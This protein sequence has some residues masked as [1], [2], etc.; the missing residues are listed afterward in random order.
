MGGLVQKVHELSG[1]RD[2]LAAGSDVF[3]APESP[4]LGGAAKSAKPRKSDAGGGGGFLS[5]F[6]KKKDKSGK[7]SKNNSRR[8]P[9]A[10]SFSHNSS[11]TLSASVADVEYL[12]VVLW[13]YEKLQE[14][15]LGARA[16]DIIEILEETDDVWCFARSGNHT[17]SLP[18]TYIDKIEL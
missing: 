6:K 9:A 8:S 18:L 10:G 16:G 7:N 2:Q 4:K 3:V 5:V 1:L 13:D 17:G 12:A 15:E 14:G 11:T